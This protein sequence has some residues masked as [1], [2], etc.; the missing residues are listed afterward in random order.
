MVRRDQW[1]VRK[2]PPTDQTACVTERETPTPAGQVLFDCAATVPKGPL[3]YKEKQYAHPVETGHLPFLEQGFGLIGKA[4]PPHSLEPTP[5]RRP[6]TEK[7][8]ALRP[9]VERSAGQRRARKRPT[10][11][12]ATCASCGG[13]LS[14]ASGACAC[15]SSDDVSFS[16][17]PWWLDLAVGHRASRRFPCKARIVAPTEAVRAAGRHREA[18]VA[19]RSTLTPGPVNTNRHCTAASGKPASRAAARR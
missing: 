13:W 9:R 18:Q 7:P 12:S 8:A 15:S 4:R 11:T 17:C 6:K 1:V 19:G 14:S 10:L 3:P 16:D 5:P 2:S